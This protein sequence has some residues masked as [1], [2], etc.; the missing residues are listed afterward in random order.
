MV[1]SIRIVDH[2]EIRY[3]QSG[4]MRAMCA[5]HSIPGFACS[6]QRT[7]LGSSGGRGRPIG[8]LV[9]WLQDG[10]NFDNPADHGRSAG[11]SYQ[12]RLDARRWFY[13]L[14]GSAH[15]ADL[16]ERKQGAGESEEPSKVHKVR[17]S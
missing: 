8:E 11:K 10:Q 5:R 2:G 14:D 16:Y 6:R 4:F 9:A 13:T 15:F 12:E 3:N 17:G 7:T 1:R